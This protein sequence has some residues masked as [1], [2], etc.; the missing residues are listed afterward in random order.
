MKKSCKFL[1]FML[2]VF[3]MTG[4]MKFQTDMKIN[5]D[6]SMDFTLTYAI[7]NS[8]VEQAKQAATSNNENLD[9]ESLKELEKQGFKTEEYS[10]SSMT[11]IKLSKT[12]NNIDDISSEKEVD[13][14]LE[15]IMNGSEQTD[16][17]TIKKGFFK[18]TYTLK[19]KNNTSEEVESDITNNNLTPDNQIDFSSDIDLSTLSSSMDMTFNINLPYKAISS[20]ATSTENDGKNLKWNLLDTNIQNITAKFELYNMNNIYL[21]IGIVIVLIIIVII[22]IKRKPKAPVGTPITVNDKP[23]NNITQNP[24]PVAPIINKT[25]NQTVAEMNNGQTLNTN[26]NSQ[27]VN[28]VS[29]NPKENINNNIKPVENNETVN[30]INPTPDNPSNVNQNNAYAVET[31]DVDTLIPTPNQQVIST[32]AVPPMQESEV[33][34]L[35]INSESQTPMQPSTNNTF[36]DEKNNIS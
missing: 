15:A 30:N 22:I 33:E 32:P 4:C 19:I 7:A 12:F 11:G 14:D 2:I 17:F 1:C 9:N 16:M 13:F 10:D 28:T 25:P 29:V 6:K 5:K 26:I 35:D 36:L 31:L 20:N 21:T 23:V 27:P 3:M 34:T 24:E 18:N 8:L